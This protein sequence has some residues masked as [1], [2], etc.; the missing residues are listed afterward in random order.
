L[1]LKIL[2]VKK[3]PSLRGAPLGAG[4]KEKLKNEISFDGNYRQKTKARQSQA[5]ED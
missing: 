5:L 1:L 2:A 3:F 4:W